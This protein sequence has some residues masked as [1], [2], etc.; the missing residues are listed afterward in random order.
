MER[1]LTL[2]RT[3][4]LDHSRLL[5]FLRN[6]RRARWSH[7]CSLD[8]DL[9]VFRPDVVWRLWRFR[10]ERASGIGLEFA[11]VPLFAD[12]EIQRSRQD[13]SRAPLVWMPMRHDL[14]ARWKFDSLNVHTGLCW[15][16]VQDCGL[17][18]RAYRCLELDLIWNFD[19]GL[20]ALSVD[21]RSPSRRTG[22]KSQGCVPQGHGSL[23]LLSDLVIV[24]LRSAATGP[25]RRAS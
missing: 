25:R 12:T 10:I 2:G 18:S 5:L 14:G 24:R 7:A 11:F 22:G 16:A 17:R 23:P 6:G 4:L 3:V 8:D 21:R 9:T 13:H 20:G 19:D 15:V 1:H